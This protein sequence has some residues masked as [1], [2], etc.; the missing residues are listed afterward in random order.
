MDRTLFDIP[1]G[2]PVEPIFSDM[3][4]D[5]IVIDGRH[6]RMAAALREKVLRAVMPRLQEG[7]RTVITVGGGSG[8]GKSEV[9]ALLAG[10]VRQAMAESGISGAVYNVAQDNYPHL[11]PKVNEKERA[12]IYAELG[13]AGLRDYLCT[14]KE[15]DFARL[16]GAAR[17]FKKGAASLDIRRMDKAAPFDPPEESRPDFSEVRALFIEGTRANCLTQSDLRVFV[18][19]SEEEAL[20]HRIKRGRDS[21]DKFTNMVIAIERDTIYRDKAGCD[22]VVNSAGE[23]ALQNRLAHR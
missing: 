1:G 13:E 21:S 11:P 20:Q 7:Q 3:K 17:E 6:I 22:A 14:Q 4:N 16:D 23:V 8:A 9:S 10:M 12:R 15:I 5:K 19:I 18:D 2:A